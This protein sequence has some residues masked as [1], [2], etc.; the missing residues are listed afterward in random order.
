MQFPPQLPDLCIQSN[1]I[2]NLKEQ[3]ELFCGTREFIEGVANALQRRLS[4]LF[5]RLQIHIPLDIT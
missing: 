1:G 3:P 4:L 5:V 2:W